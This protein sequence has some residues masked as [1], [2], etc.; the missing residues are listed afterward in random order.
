MS[1][2]MKRLQKRHQSIQTNRTSDGQYL[3]GRTKFR[4]GKHLQILGFRMDKQEVIET[5]DKVMP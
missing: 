3:Y 4:D 5:N 1:Q 2:A